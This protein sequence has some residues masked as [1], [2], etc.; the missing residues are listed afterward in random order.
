MIIM[1]VEY[2]YSADIVAVDREYFPI[3][4][5]ITRPREK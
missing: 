4:F 5:A 1:Y 3:H 2:V